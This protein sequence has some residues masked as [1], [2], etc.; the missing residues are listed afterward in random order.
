MENLV[1]KASFVSIAILAIGLGGSAAQASI[2]S[3]V[4]DAG[5]QGRPVA[6]AIEPANPTAAKAAEGAQR[7]SGVQV[8]WC[9][10]Y[11]DQNNLPCR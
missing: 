5:G 11:R 1:M 2:P 7:N 3:N 9:Y 4:R 10:W 8:A 6:H